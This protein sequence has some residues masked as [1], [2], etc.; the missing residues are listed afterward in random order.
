MNNPKENIIWRTLSMEELLEYQAR[1]TNNTTF[2]R[3]TLPTSRWGNI[4]NKESTTSK[5]EIDHLITKLKEDGH[6]VRK[7][8]DKK[9]NRGVFYR[10]DIKNHTERLC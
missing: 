5:E 8:I 4:Y 10:I 1:R 9:T 2:I 6:T 3:P 7:R